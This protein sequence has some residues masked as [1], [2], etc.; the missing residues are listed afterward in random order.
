MHEVANPAPRTLNPHHECHTRVFWCCGSQVAKNHI[1]CYFW[2]GKQME[3]RLNP[4][5]FLARTSVALSVLQYPRH[6]VHSYCIA[7]VWLSHHE[8]WYDL[9]MRHP[10]N[11]YHLVVITSEWGHH[12]NRKLRCSLFVTW[13][14]SWAATAKRLCCSAEVDLAEG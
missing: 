6:Q 8:R 1:F 7:V 3:P 11:N 14:R 5:P 10:D 2:S 9:N 12:L 4:T 13:D